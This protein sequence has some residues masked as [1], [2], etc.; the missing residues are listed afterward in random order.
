M[1]G[2]VETVRLD[3]RFCG[4]GEVEVE[5]TEAMARVIR[6]LFCGVTDFT[7]RFPASWERLLRSARYPAA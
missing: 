4:A 1:I 3:C 6:C 5:R 2:P 7:I